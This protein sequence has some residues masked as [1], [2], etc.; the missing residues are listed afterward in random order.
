MLRRLRARRGTVRR[1]GVLRRSVAA[2][3]AVAAAGM[4]AAAVGMGV[5]VA[6]AV[7]ATAVVA[8]GRQVM[9]AL[10]VTARVLAAAGIVASRAAN[11]PVTTAVAAGPANTLVTPALAKGVRTTLVTRITRLRRA[12]KAMQTAIARLISRAR[13]T[14]ITAATVAAVR[15]LNTNARSKPVG[16]DVPVSRHVAFP[17]AVD[18]DA[19]VAVGRAGAGKVPGGC[20]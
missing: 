18:S 15:D 16:M 17:P 7:V 8:A 6:M 2:A 9:R 20:R 14:R 11:M 12:V 5:V 3:A 4:P 19:R 10:V 13:P 1:S